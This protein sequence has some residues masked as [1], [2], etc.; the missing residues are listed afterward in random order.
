[1][2]RINEHT[3]ELNG[4]QYHLSYYEKPVIIKNGLNL[5]VKPVLR[6][7]IET[8]NLPIELCNKNGNLETTNSLAN[9]VLKYFSKNQKIEKD[10]DHYINKNN[11]GTVEINENNKLVGNFTWTKTNINKNNTVQNTVYIDKV[12]NK[13]NTNNNISI[14][15][16][17]ESII[18]LATKHEIKDFDVHNEEHLKLLN[19]RTI[20]EVK[21]N[22]GKLPTMPPFEKHPYLTPLI[23][24]NNIS[25]LMIGTFPPISYLCDN[26]RL[27]NLNFNKKINPPDIPYF[28]GNYSSLWKYCPI[29]FDEIGKYDRNVQPKLIKDK[30]T[31]KG[32]SYTDIILYCQRAL[33]N[34]DGVLSYTADDTLLNNIVVNNSIFETLVACTNINRIYFTNSSLFGSN[35]RE[36]H[37]FDKNGNFILDKRDAFRLFLK[38]A[39]DYGF[40]I[41]IANIKNP[42]NWFNINERIRSSLDRKKINNEFTTKVTVILRLTKGSFKGVYHV[43]SAVSPAAID[44]GKVRKNKCVTNF[45]KIYKV[46]IEKSPM[47][48]LKFVLLSFFNNDIERLE[49]INI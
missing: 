28:H 34:K 36:N 21:Q 40:T 10:K 22:K 15:L 35:N 43:F 23:P 32:I 31:S 6:E 39:N 20:S 7:Y 27:Q 4:E 24:N 11:D 8:Y 38:G 14:L 33:K 12:I 47:E 9:K 41:E 25:G 3:F 49:K 42:D 45:S 18:E 1:M 37:I 17:K 26:L 44:R 19:E 13:R 5:M 46:S 29:D 2:P 48:L 30:L 16:T